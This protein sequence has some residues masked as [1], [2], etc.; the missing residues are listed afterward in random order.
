MNGTYSQ[1]NYM[2]QAASPRNHFANRF[3]APPSFLSSFRNDKY[4]DLPAKRS[5]VCCCGTEQRSSVGTRIQGIVNSTNAP[6]R[7]KSYTQ[8]PGREAKRSASPEQF[9]TLPFTSYFLL[10]TSPPRPTSILTVTVGPSTPT[11]ASD[12]DELNQA[13]TFSTDRLP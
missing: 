11:V 3:Y 9:H 2:P 13:T 7:E 12:L 6:L 8:A 10:T 1:R 5:V 4:Q